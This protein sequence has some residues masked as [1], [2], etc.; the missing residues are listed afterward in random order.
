MSCFRRKRTTRSG[1]KSM[2]RI[3]TIEFVD[4]ADIVR[5]VTGFS[6][7]SAS[8]ELERNIKRLVSLRQAGGVPSTELNRFIESAPAPLVTK[9]AEWGILPNERAARGQ[10]LSE[11]IDG[12]R[13]ELAAKGNTPRHVKNFVAKVTAII[14]ECKWASLSDINLPAAQEWLMAKRQAN[15][16][17][18]TAN[19][20]IWAAKGFC[21]WLR[22]VGRLSENPLKYWQ[23]LN[24]RSDRRKERH[25]FTVEEL[26][27]LLAAT[28]S[29]PVVHGLTGPVRA[30]LYRTA[31]ETGFR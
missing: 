28:E 20:Y 7:H 10:A 22:K 3:W 15:M 29:G 23:I 11:H 16:A 4:H 8:R 6:D 31:V 25:A 2:D 27:K 12:W 19:A 18:A 9:L 26:G 14:A 21:R 5:R 30:L 24:E 17:S 1:K 13:N